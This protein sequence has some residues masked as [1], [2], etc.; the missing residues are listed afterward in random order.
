V[1]ISAAEVVADS[2]KVSGTVRDVN[3]TDVIGISVVAVV[4][5]SVAVVVVAV[6]VAASSFAVSVAATVEGVV[7]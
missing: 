4:A 7:R 1:G 2:K 6:V 5:A 3:V